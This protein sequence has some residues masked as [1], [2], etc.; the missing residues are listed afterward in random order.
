MSNVP[1]HLPPDFD[2]R[3]KADSIESVVEAISKAQERLTMKQSAEILHTY[4][5]GRNAQGLIAFVALLVTVAVIVSAF[6][7]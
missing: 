5:L 1:D 6:A 2:K 7:S 4:E 3:A